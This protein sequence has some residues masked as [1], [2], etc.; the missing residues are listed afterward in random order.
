MVALAFQR[1]WNTVANGIWSGVIPR[2]SGPGPW[3]A[4]LRG[5]LDPDGN[6]G[7]ATHNAIEIAFRNQGQGS[8][9]W[10]QIVQQAKAAGASDAGPGPGGAR[11]AL[12]EHYLDTAEQIS[13]IVGLKTFCLVASLRE[14]N[15]NPNAANTTASEAAAA[16]RG[17]NNAK[18]TLFKSSPYRNEPERWC[19][20]SG[21][22]FGFLPS[23]ALGRSGFYNLDPYSVKDPASSVAYIT[24]FVHSII[25]NFLTE[26]PA[27]QRNWLAVRRSMASLTTMRDWQE[28]GETAKK[29][30]TRMAEFSVKAGI[31]PDFMFDI[32]PVSQKYPGNAAMLAAMKAIA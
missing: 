12:L 29:V 3:P 21:G 28:N 15:W 16:C 32:P 24:A 31:D 20:G 22:W 8:L 11:R 13:G 26:L 23:S 30:R 4:A 6:A 10:Q 14:S 7:K 5:A 19:W 1:D 27:N 9:V 25:K 17:F 18:A 2:P